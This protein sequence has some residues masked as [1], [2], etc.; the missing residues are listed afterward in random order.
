MFDWYY[1]SHTIPHWFIILFIIM[2]GVIDIF[3]TMSIIVAFRYR[4]RKYKQII[5]NISWF[6]ILKFPIFLVS[7]LNIK[8]LTNSI[9][10]L[11]T[12]MFSF[13]ASALIIII[14]VRFY[15]MIK[16]L[17]IIWLQILFK[18]ILLIIGIGIFLYYLN[19]DLLNLIFF[20][21]SIFSLKY[22]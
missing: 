11:L 16:Q 2:S 8:G 21:S 7:H 5:N 3:I 6:A 10:T 4:N 1:T 13:T 17:R 9:D 22:L 18:L 19:F 12:Y 15:K 20:V 14:V